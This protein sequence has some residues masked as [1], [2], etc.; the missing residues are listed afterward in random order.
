MFFD[1]G[2]AD[3]SIPL[4]ILDWYQRNGGGCPN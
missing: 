3:Y 2:Y 4:G 1:F